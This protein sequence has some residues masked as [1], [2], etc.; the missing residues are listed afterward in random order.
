MMLFLQKT[1]ENM[2]EHVNSMCKFYVSTDLLDKNI[3]FY[4]VKQLKNL[5]HILFYK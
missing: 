2:K 3:K 1:L 4:Q 5:N